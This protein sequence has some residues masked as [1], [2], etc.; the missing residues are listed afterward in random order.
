MGP[1][2]PPPPLVAQWAHVISRFSRFLDNLQ[3]TLLQQVDG[4]TKKNGV[5]SCLNAAYYGSNSDIDNS[6]YIGS[7][8][9][10]TAIRPPR[11]VDIYFVLP[12]SAYWRLSAYKHNGQSALLQEVKGV[13]QN[14]YPKTTYIRGD[15]PVVLVGFES[16]SVEVVPAFLLDN[17]GYWVCSTK[18]GG[19]CV[20]TSP[21]AEIVHINSSDQR[22]GANLRPLVRM[23]KSWQANCSVPI[24]SFHL[25]LITVEYLDQ[26]PWRLSGFFWYDWLVRDFFLYLC[27][28][29]NT[30]VVAP[31]TGEWMW[32]GDAWKS[33]AETAYGRAVKA[34]AFEAQ[35]LMI[36]AG[37]EWQKIFGL[38]IPKV[39]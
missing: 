8:G 32:L 6:F 21:W 18:N 1:L 36:A 29:A 4:Q 13:L 35:N 15:G 26:S 20:Q 37:E 19:A 7:W 22:N 28:R 11:D 34:S 30:F 5:V 10:G 31:G 25:E 23:L 33:K 3:L 39:V 14:R 9:K 17:G 38:D 12:P 24:K 16:Y 2:H 27:N